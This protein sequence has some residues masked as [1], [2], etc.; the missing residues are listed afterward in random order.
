MEGGVRI[1]FYYPIR[2]MIL[3]ARFVAYESRQILR[4]MIESF[5]A[6]VFMMFT[7]MFLVVGVVAIVGEKFFHIMIE[8]TM[9]L[10]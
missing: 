9:W 1:G 2:T 7:I 10:L 4:T 3:S 8:Q 5:R 6:R